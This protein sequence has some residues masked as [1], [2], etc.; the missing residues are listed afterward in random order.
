MKVVNTVRVVKTDSNHPEYLDGRLDQYVGQTGII[1][2]RNCATTSDCYELEFADE[3]TLGRSIIDRT[4]F[5]STFS[6]RK[7]GN[8]K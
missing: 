5:E 4:P 8:K 7:Q 1:H 2:E 6:G 3:V